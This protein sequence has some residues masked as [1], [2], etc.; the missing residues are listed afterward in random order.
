MNNIAI[1]GAGGFGREM[2]SLIEDINV[3][4]ET[5][6]QI[7][8]FY[9]DSKPV[10]ELVQGLPVLGGINDLNKVDYNLS[11]VLG[12]G[13]PILKQ[14]IISRINNNNN[15]H[16]PTLI[17]PSVI[18][19]NNNVL[20]GK[21]VILTAGNILTCDINIGDFVTLNLACTVGHDTVIKEYASFM[22]SVNI[23]GEVIINEAVYVGT[24]AKV[25]NQL[26]IGKKSIIGAGAIVAKSI[27]ENCTA[28]GIPAKPIK[29][30]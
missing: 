28:V 15:I 19:S 9:D 18:R 6:Y 7:I 10:G 1:I 29:F 16:Y 21:G 24:G 14:N 27:P 17:H 23:S 3:S 26:K 5:K 20:I 11:I 25:I 4:I 12:V 22:P 8:G 2:K 30:H 13:D